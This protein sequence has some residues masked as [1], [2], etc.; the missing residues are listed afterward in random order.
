MGDIFVATDETLGRRVA[1][2]IL[3]ERYSRD[4]A[5]RRRFK[6]EALAAARL[7]H[8]GIVAL[9]EAGRD[10]DAARRAARSQAQD[11][12]VPSQASCAEMGHGFGG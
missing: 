4:E 2:K 1:V 5:I 6:R 10:D 12:L 9:Y 7:G 11:A 8:A 3:A